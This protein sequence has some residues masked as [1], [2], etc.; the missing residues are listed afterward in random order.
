MSKFLSFCI[1]VLLVGSVAAGGW[2]AW[3]GQQGSRGGSGTRVLQ[4]AHGLPTHHPV[5]R[6]LEEMARLVAEKSHGR[7]KFRLFH[8]EQLGTE[9]ECLEKAQAGTLA[10]TKVSAAVAGNF[11]P[12]YRTFSLPY[13]FRDEGHF[14]RVLD[15]EIGAGMLERLSTKGDG[16][17][18]G[19]RGLAWY[20][21]GSRSFYAKVPLRGPDDL[22]GLKVRTMSDPVAMDT[23]QALGGSPTPIAW[24]E[25]Y[26]ALHQGT[27]DGAE[28]NP[29]SFLT[30]RHFEICKH[31]LLDH[32]SRIPDVLVMSE[33]VWQTL[34]GNEKRWI[35]GAARESGLFQ[36][37]V[38]AEESAK[39]LEELKASG[40]SVVETDPVAFVGRTASVMEK[41]ATGEI[42]G[43][44]DKI[45]AVP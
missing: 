26:T 23:V 43:L 31:Y 42:G 40:V 41:Y 12:V 39:A 35:A 17:P 25:L 4:V 19:L 27:V 34:N 3:L 24:G 45:R 36:R 2:F 8:S 30:S 5:H 44:V 20:D 11:V 7:L 16:S 37:G 38:W 18:S 14:W 29:P 32:H 28:N 9:V 10:I 22:R 21:S 6:G 15:G 13:L 1:L 33:A